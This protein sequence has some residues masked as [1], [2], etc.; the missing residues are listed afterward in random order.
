MDK[1]PFTPQ[2]SYHP[3]VTLFE[4]LEELDISVKEFAIRTAMPEKTIITFI[5]G[6]TSLT[7][8]MAVAFESVT[9][10]PVHFWIQKQENYNEYVARQKSNII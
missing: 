1:E 6:N 2:V 5:K 9:G 4:K 7:P 3:G 10:I 8:D